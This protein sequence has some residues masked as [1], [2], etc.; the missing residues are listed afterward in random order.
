V[1]LLHPFFEPVYIMAYA[2]S[3]PVLKTA[4]FSGVAPY[5][6][7]IPVAKKRRVKVNKVDGV[8]LY[9]LEDFEVVAEDKFI[10]GHY[11]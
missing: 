7:I 3:P 5:Y 2:A 9:G 6:L 10:Y 8:R 1:H 4:D 11:E